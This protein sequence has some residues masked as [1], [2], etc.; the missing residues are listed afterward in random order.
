M[1]NYAKIENGVVTNI[2]VCEDSEV[3]MLNGKYIK[4]SESTGDPCIGEPYDE[5]ANRFIGKKPYSSWI[6]SDSFIW[7]SPTG[8]APAGKTIW[9]E[10]NQE[11]VEKLS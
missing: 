2:I 9:D 6:L 11:W 10:P 5:D 1:S 4:Q 7:E 8:P 3:S